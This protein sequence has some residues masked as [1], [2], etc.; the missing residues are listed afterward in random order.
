MNN[1]EE[2]FLRA[3]KGEQSYVRRGIKCHK[4]LGIKKRSL[5][6]IGT[7]LYHVKQI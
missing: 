4:T 3:S 2:K 5:F 1:D 7:I 6:F